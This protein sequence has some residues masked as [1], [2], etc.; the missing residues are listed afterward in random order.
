MY[1][2]GERKVVYPRFYHHEADFASPSLDSQGGYCKTTFKHKHREELLSATGICSLCHLCIISLCLVGGA[3]PVCS[4]PAGSYCPS[5]TLT[6][7]PCPVG[8]YCSGG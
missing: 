4:A 2:R 6:V 8:Y 7:T 3:A 1:C 5:G